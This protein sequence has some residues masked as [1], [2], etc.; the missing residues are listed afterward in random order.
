[1]NRGVDFLR[2][3]DFDR[4]IEALK[5][6]TTVNPKLATAFSNL[7]TA[8]QKKGDLD[9]AIE[10]YSRAIALR[11]KYPVAFSNRAYAVLPERRARSRDRR[12]DARDRARSRNCRWRTRIS[13]TPWRRRA[14]PHGGAQLSARP[15]AESR[16][17]GRGRDAPGAGETRRPRSDEDEKTK[18]TTD[19]APAGHR[20]GQLYLA[21]ILAIFVAELALLFWGLWSRRPIV[22]LVAVFVTVPLMRSAVNAIR[23]CFVRIARRKAS[24][25]GPNR[26]RALYDWSKRSGARSGRRRSTASPSPVI[27]MRARSPTVAVAS[28]PT[29]DAGARIAR[30]DDAVHGELRA[31]IAH[32]LAHFSSAHDAYAA[33][34]Y[35]T[36]RSWWAL[37]AALN[38]RLAT[39]VYVYWLIRWYV[40]R[41][42]TAAAEVARRHELV[43]D[44]VAAT[45]SGS[46]AAADALVVFESGARFADETHWPAI[47]ISHETAA[48]PP[49]PYCSDAEVG[50]AHD[51]D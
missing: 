23:A 46:R 35:R 48:E 27:S 29:P 13:D 38:R 6:A 44:R 3:G 12:C 51:L 22:G 16:S 20:R 36:H 19:E 8:Y 10:S 40:P 37:L 9:A 39:P 14:M 49:R 21:G 45:V 41:L 11:P 33:W 1:M 15:G 31:V 26:G 5:Y 50:R 24:P 34:V 4:S 17:G 7:G 42:N 28:P 30:A 43:A 18:K 2:Q 32:E 47:Q 25:L